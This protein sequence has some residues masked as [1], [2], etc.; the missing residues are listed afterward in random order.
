MADTGTTGIALVQMRCEKG[1]VAENL[2]ATRAYIE[3]AS[4]R[5]AA[6]ICFPEMSITGYANPVR[7]PE[8]VVRLDGPEVARF[9][10]FTRDTA[11]TV[12][13]G[14]IEDNLAGLPFITQVVARRGDLVGSYRKRNVAPDE[15]G[16]FA[17]GVDAAVFDH[18]GVRFG[19][20]VCADIDEPKV[21]ADCAAAGARVIFEAAAPGLEGDQATRN[22]RTG[23]D[24]WRGECQSKL[25]AYAREHGVHIGVA[26]QAGRTVDEDFPGGGYVFDPHGLPIAEMADWHEGLLVA[27]LP[28]YGRV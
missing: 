21:F 3:A 19:L 15:V 22:W 23:Y 28:V 26:T 8:A 10:S 11:A 17:P 4:G 27:A 12:I 14:I 6:I 13:A 9:V 7:M 25:G 1:R 18:D 2:A 24:W 20:A 16:F 5:G